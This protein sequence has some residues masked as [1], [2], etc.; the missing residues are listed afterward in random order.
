M[1]P[2]SGIWV[3]ALLLTSV[4]AMLTSIGRLVLAAACRFGRSVAPVESLVIR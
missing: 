3:E 4:L 2:T 1:V